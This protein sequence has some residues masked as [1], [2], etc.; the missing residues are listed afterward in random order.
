[1]FYVPETH[2]MLKKE[3]K[4]SQKGNNEADLHFS[5]ALCDDEALVESPT[6]KTLERENFSAKLSL[7]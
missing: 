7:I 5:K 2:E 4:P 6:E 3:I 1:M